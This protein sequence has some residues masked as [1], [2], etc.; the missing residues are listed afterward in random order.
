MG[1]ILLAEDEVHVRRALATVLKRDGHTVHEAENGKVACRLLQNEPAGWDA[2]MI[3]L[4]MPEMGGMDLLR[5]VQA[6]F[7][8]LPAIVITA[9]STPEKT[10][11]AMN[12]GAFDYI[13]KPFDITHVKDVAARAVETRKLHTIHPEPLS[14]E[15]SLSLSS[16]AVVGSSSAMQ[17]VYKLAGR[18]A[19]SAIPVL[20]QGESGT[21][22]E[23]IARSIH[24][25]G[26][27][28]GAPFVAIN[29]AAIPETLLESELF[30]H[31]KGSFIKKEIVLE[32]KMQDVLD[33][34][35]RFAPGI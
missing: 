30:G 5:F 1:T 26:Q 35:V 24:E 23:V 14:S 7:P 6:E 8:Q 11:E 4:H 10:M 22:K 19:S 15:D 17:N 12:L 2:L 29:C 21:G 33:F 27:R 3:D 28:A 34:I 32:T 18:V 16:L 31:E 20:I 13:V 25:T 9:Y